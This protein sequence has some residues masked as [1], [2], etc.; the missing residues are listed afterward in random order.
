MLFFIYSRTNIKPNRIATLQIKY[1]PRYLMI[2]IKA[3]GCYLTIK[4]LPMAMQWDFSTLNSREITSAISEH[5]FS[6]F[7]KPATVMADNYVG[8][9]IARQLRTQYIEGI[10]GPKYYTV[11][12]KS[13]LRLTQGHWKRNHWTDHKE[14]TISRVIWRWILSWPW[15]LG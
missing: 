5:L 2:S 10:Y 13:R 4:F 7:C 3:H 14:L 15:N 8:K 9:Q 11:T 1:T 12:L 6:I